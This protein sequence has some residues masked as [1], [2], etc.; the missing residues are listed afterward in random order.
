MLEWDGKKNCPEDHCCLP[1]NIFQ[2]WGHNFNQTALNLTIRKQIGSDGKKHVFGVFDKVRFIPACSATETSWKIEI[3]LIESL[4]VILSNKRIIKALI[5]LLKRVG[6]SAPLLFEKR[7][8][9]CRQV[10]L[11]RGTSRPIM[12]TLIRLIDSGG[13]CSTFSHQGYFMVTFFDN[14]AAHFINFLGAV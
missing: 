14:A 2:S 8:K 10:F 3:S 12:K 6:W 7:F 4:D 9:P 13:C 11:H 1:N 5:R